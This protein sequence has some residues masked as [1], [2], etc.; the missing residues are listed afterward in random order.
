M[1]L[2][3][4]VL[5]DILKKRKIHQFIFDGL[6]SEYRGHVKAMHLGGLMGLFSKCA[7]EIWT[8]LNI[9]DMTLESMKMKE[10]ILVVLFLLHVLLFS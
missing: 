5:I 4:N 2:M 3:L 8:S 10:K 9:W 6:N 1:V 7:D